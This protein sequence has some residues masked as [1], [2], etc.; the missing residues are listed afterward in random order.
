[1]TTATMTRK[2]TDAAKSER[3]ARFAALTEMVEAF[4]LDELGAAG[5]RRYAGFLDHYSERN[6]VLIMSQRPSATRLR[7]FNG[8]KQEGRKVR[9]GAKAIWILAPAGQSDRNAVSEPVD[10]NAPITDAEGKSARR[11]FKMIALFDLGQTE[12]I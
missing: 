6:T 8:W 4:D 9:K 3:A 12:E 1:M 5:Q 10:S 2:S 7:M 11:Y